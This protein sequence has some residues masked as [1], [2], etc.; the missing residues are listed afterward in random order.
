MIKPFEDAAFKMKPGD[1]A[2]VE[3]SFGYHV[4]KVDEVRP[5]HVDTFQE[6]EP[7]IVDGMRTEAGARLVRQ[8]IDEDL[9]A[10]LSGVTLQ[11][12]AK[13]RGLDVVEPPSFAKGEPI[14]GLKGDTG[15]AQKAFSMDAG[16]VGTVPGPAP[17]LMRVIERTPSRI[18]PLKEIEAKVRDAYVRAMAEA[19]ARTEARKL[20]GQMKTPADFKRVAETNN[21]SIHNVDSFDRSTPS[22][23]GLGDFPEVADETGSVATVPGLIGR[24]M[25]RDGNAYIF[26][27]TARSDPSPEAWKSAKDSFMQE[28]LAGRRAQAWSRY[29]EELKSKAKITIDTD[30]FA[31]NSSDS[32]E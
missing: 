2:I 26:E 27:V 1:I 23:P 32:S 17:F 29:L 21:L 9:S 8:A 6:A 11:D 7:R 10:A 16:Q 3:T 31:N 14:Q 13:K 4:L 15:L 12:L 28:Y 5:A 19:A 30:Q 24:V 20:I 18:P 22:I 25:E